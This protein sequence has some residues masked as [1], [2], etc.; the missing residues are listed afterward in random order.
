MAKAGDLG[1]GVCPQI[2]MIVAQGSILFAPVLAR[3]VFWV[4][5][6]AGHGVGIGE[7]PRQITVAATL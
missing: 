5:G 3:H 2:A 4:G 6:R 1:K 7:P